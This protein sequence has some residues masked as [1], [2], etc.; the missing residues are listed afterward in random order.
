MRILLIEDDARLCEAVA[1]QLE[2]EG[3]EVDVCHDGESGLRWSLQQAHEIILLDRMLPELDGISA[4]Q[5]MRKAGITAPVLLMTA[6]GSVTQRVE[7]LDAGADDYIIKPFAA[8]ELLARIRAMCRR[9]RQWE[10]ITSLRVGDV[11]YDPAG[12]TLSGQDGTC[13][14]SKRESELLETLL[15]NIG[16]IL[17]RLVLLSRVWGPDAPVEEGNLDNYI[18]FL[19]RRLRS[20]GSVLEIKT[21]RG[22]GY[23]LEFPGDGGDR[24]K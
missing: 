11:S 1:Y 12:K 24:G 5:R 19:R 6:L 16:Q 22:V 9:P 14:L 3:Y 23:Q 4:L 20:V 10:E 13:S 18:Y 15:R 17:P 7:G 8:E 2:R 21:V